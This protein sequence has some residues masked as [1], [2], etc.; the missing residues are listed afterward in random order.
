[1]YFALRAISL[2]RSVFLSFVRPPCISSFRSFGVPLC[3]S[4][5]RYSFHY[6][7]RYILLQFARSFSFFIPLFHVSLF[8]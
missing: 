2:V 3:I 8:T 7:V 5:V 6:I 4:L 1:M